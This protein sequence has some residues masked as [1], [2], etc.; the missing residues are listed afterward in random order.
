[1]QD[2]YVNIVGGLKISE[3]AVD[4]AVA[5]AIASSYREI[6][7]PPEMVLIGEVGL[8]GELRTAGQLERRLTEAAKLGFTKTIYPPTTRKPNL[9]KGFRDISVAT[10]QETIQASCSR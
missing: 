6:K 3:P 5:A 8:S 7:G 4:L 9:P 10:L 1:M 2:V